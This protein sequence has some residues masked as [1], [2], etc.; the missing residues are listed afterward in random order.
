M[1]RIPYG[2]RSAFRIIMSTASPVLIR[3]ASTS[4]GVSGIPE[5]SAIP[6]YRKPVHSRK[7]S[8]SFS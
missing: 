5:K 6:V 7:V 3:D 4:T 2:E 1:S 8:R